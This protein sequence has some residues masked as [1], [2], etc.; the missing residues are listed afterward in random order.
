MSV[1]I[2]THMK[3]IIDFIF[4]ATL[5]TFLS[6]C[7]KSDDKGK[8]SK[9]LTLDAVQGEKCTV[10]ASGQVANLDIVALDFECG[11]EYSTNTS[12]KKDSTWQVSAEKNYS[13][14]V[15]SVTLPQLRSEQKYYYR[16]YYINQLLISYGETKQ[17]T[18]YWQIL[19]EDDLIGLWIADNWSYEFYDDYTGQRSQSNGATQSFTWS[20]DGNELELQIKLLDDLTRSV[21]YII[22]SLFDNGFYVYNASDA[23]KQIISF[24]YR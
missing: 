10:I 24:R 20:L 11:I 14:D 17:F 9:I 2:L 21:V 18:F 13:E 16:A 12:F 1:F 3:R 5:I 7:D 8:E 4:I 19:S 22:D 6:S 15:Y 23:D